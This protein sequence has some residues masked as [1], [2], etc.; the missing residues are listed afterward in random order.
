MDK[1]QLDA[2]SDARLMAALGGDDE[3]ETVEKSTDIPSHQQLDL[4][5]DGE[6]V[7]ML[8]VYVD[9]PSHRLH[10]ARRWR[11]TRST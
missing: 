5:E 3:P 2:D 10:V 8:F 1:E 6:P 9:E 7:Q 11:G 4:T